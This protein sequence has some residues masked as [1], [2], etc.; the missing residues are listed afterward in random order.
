VARADARQHAQAGRQ[1]LR[2]AGVDE[3]VGEAA[4]DEDR[5]VGE[6]FDAAREDDVGVAE[7]DLVVGVGDGLVSGGA[8]AVQ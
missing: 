1:R 7:G 4:G 2:L 5:D 3:N 8:G 6:R